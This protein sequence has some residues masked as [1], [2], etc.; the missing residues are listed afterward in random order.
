MKP[1][2]SLKQLKNN[3]PWMLAEDIPNAYFTLAQIFL[4]SFVNNLNKSSDVNYK[5]TFASFK[6]YDLSFYFGEKDSF[7][8]AQ[9]VLDKIIKNPSFG[10]KI[11]KNIFDY[12]N[13]LYKISESIKVDSFE[14][15]SNGQIS[16]FYSLQN[17]T[18][19]KLYSWGWLPNAVDMFHNNFT[20]YLKEELRK[21]TNLESVEDILVSLSVSNLSNVVNEEEYSFLNLA[22]L[23]QGR[24]NSNKFKKALEIH[25]EKYFHLKFLWLGEDGVYDKNYFLKEVNDFIGTK[26]IADDILKEK[27]VER[28]K[29]L[30][31]KKVIFK[32]YSFSK[33]FIRLFKIYADFSVTKA[34]RRHAQIFW[35]YKINFINEEIAK[36]LGVTLE[37]VRFMKSEEICKYL[38]LEKVDND[39]LNELKKRKNFFVYYAEEN[40]DLLLSGKDGKEFLK[41]NIKNR[42]LDSKTEIIGQPA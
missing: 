41:Q 38:I 7:N 10:E 30:R 6:G 17:K 21:T 39:F 24:G 12:S 29:A 18:H 42:K 27:K 19:I 2:I 9:H 23:K 4:S 16:N 40:Q 13:D 3:D 22:S 31:K 37:D 15:M 1:N 14:K 36:R 33:N 11:N 28:K 20:D 35:S 26:K 5:K 32:K 8:F 34:Y 25:C